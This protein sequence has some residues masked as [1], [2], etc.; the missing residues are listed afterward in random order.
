M[1]T[2]SRCFCFS[3]SVFAGIALILAGMLCSP[4]VALEAASP[5]G[6]GTSAS[7]PAASTQADATRTENRSFRNPG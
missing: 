2:D 5:E 3:Y 6:A 7:V 4:A 1:F